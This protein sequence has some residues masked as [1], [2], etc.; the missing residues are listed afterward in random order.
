MKQQEVKLVVEFWPSGV[1]R[2]SLGE[3]DSRDDAKAFISSQC[4]NGNLTPDYYY[5]IAHVF[6]IT[7]RS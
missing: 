2:K 3:F 5:G 1:I 6:K 4:A 7:E